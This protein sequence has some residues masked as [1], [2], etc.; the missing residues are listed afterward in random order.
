[1]LH[2]GP[3]RGTSLRTHCSPEGA[4]AALEVVSGAGLLEDAGRFVDLLASQLLF[5]NFVF[6]VCRGHV[7]DVRGGSLP[8]SFLQLV[9]GAL[10]ITLRDR[11]VISEH[12][13][14]NGWLFGRVGP[15]D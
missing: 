2:P 4:R 15:L 14:N 13:V 1:M 8:C 12:D 5:F 7:L 9:F 10:T 3:R 6:P 11:G